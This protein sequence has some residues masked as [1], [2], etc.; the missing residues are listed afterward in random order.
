MHNKQIYNNRTGGARVRNWVMQRSNVAHPYAP[1][2]LLN[3]LLMSPPNPFLIVVAVLYVVLVSPSY[4]QTQT[5][6]QL[7]QINQTL[8]TTAT[9]INALRDHLGKVQDQLDNLQ[10]QLNQTDQRLKPDEDM[11]KALESR[12]DITPDESLALKKFNDRS[13]DLDS[14]TQKIVNTQ[15]D[16]AKVE[17]DIAGRYF[18][19][20]AGVL[21]TL[22]IAV[23]IGLVTIRIWAENR[24]KTA[25]EKI[26][27]N[28]KTANEKID[29]NFKKKS[30]DFDARIT[31]LLKD[32]SL[33][34]IG[35]AC[36][37][38]AIPWWKGYEDE[39][40][41]FLRDNNR[42]SNSDMFQDFL[43]D[44]IPNPDMF[45]Q[46]VM[47]AKN[48]TERGRSALDRLEKGHCQQD[49]EAFLV[50]AQ[51]QNHWV[52]HR[53]AEM[54]CRKLDSPVETSEIVEAAEECL[55]LSLDSRVEALWADLQQTS[56][57]ALIQHGD[58]QSKEKGRQA[59]RALLKGRTPGPE[60]PRP[61]EKWLLAI[62]EECFPLS[63]DG[64]ARGDP[65][66]LGNVPLPATP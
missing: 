33:I 14:I 9:T 27:D 31:K 58:D 20:F 4:A 47:A 16:I 28:L 43:G 42:R 53:A 48:L 46:N 6:K 44:K 12:H 37:Q 26:D 22:G 15:S 5:Q 40:Q 23:S 2:L 51:L 36:V 29:E 35:E 56:A 54:I 1:K 3:I 7:N 24:I 10:K 62:W 39:Y 30:D 45:I 66:L 18:T 64:A 63:A 17:L 25:N 49:K 59:M 8:S 50:Y 13:V 55:K 19:L 61:S 65:F 41:E 21:T 52:Y 60:F 34:T 11:I 38:L 57:V 32:G